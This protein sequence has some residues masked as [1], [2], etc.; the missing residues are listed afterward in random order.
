L[1]H[2]FFALVED[3]IKLVEEQMRTETLEY[4]PD[5][6]AVLE[7]LLSSGGKR[8]R[9][10]VTLLAGGMLDADEDHILNLAAAVEL[11]HTA[12]LVH[13]DLID[14]AF[15]R[16][17]I[18]TLNTRWSPGATVLA[19]DYIFAKAAGFAAS[20][21]N[22]ELM[23]IFSETLATIVSGEITQLFNSR[24]KVSREDYYKRIYAKTASLFRASTLCAAMVS[25]VDEAV[26]ASMETFG[27]EIGMAFQIVDDILDYTGEQTT[28]GKPVASDLRQGLVTLPGIYYAE[29]YPE[30]ENLQSVLNGVYDDE[31]CMN[32]LVESIRQSG[33]IQQAMEEAC[34]FI[35][36]GI[37][38][39]EYLPDNQEHQAL[40]DLAYYI[41]D[42]DI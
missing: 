19:G 39:I 3:R 25:S 27:Y 29:A 5:L 15:L 13:D 26:I 34:Q 33:S 12:T 7:Y 9:P 17:G 37:T 28:V 41:V 31:D 2:S 1:D 32:K 4:H 23:R 14:G 30:D 36:R 8:I 20:T 22:I 18:P 40:V 42:R 6:Q 35:D 24:G 16:R 21:N 11:L 38:A 10:V